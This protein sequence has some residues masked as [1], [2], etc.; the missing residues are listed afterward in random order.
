MVELPISF[1]EKL[2]N[3]LG[4]EELE[5]YLEA[6]NNPRYYGLRVNNKKIST[7][8]FLKISPFDLKPIPWIANGFFY[9]GENI[10]PAKHPYFF[11]GLYYLQ[12]PSAM[13][14]A[15]RLPV[16]AGDRVLD[17][18]AAPGGKSTELAARIGD[19]GLLVS[20]DMSFSR[21]KGLLKNI[22]LFGIGN[23]LVISEDGTKLEKYFP[24]Y[25][26]GILLDAPCSGEGMFRKNSKM[27]TAWESEGPEFF[28][29]IQ[30][31]LIISAAHM[32]KPGGHLLYST[33]TFDLREN[34]EVIQYLL[35]NESDMEIVDMMPY[36]GFYK[37]I[38]LARNKDLEKTV[39]IF[40]QRMEAEGH[41][42]AL[43]HKKKTNKKDK[44]FSSIYT[45]KVSKNVLKSDGYKSLLDFLKDINTDKTSVFGEKN[46]P[47]DTNRIDIKEDKVYYMPEATPYLP[48]LR[49]AR[50]GLLL[51]EIKRDRFE[52]SQ[53]LAC[54]L[55]KESFGKVLNF[56]KD[57]IRVSKYLKGETIDVDDIVSSKEKGY[58]LVCVDGFSLGWGKLSGGTLKNK[59]LVGWRLRS[60][61]QDI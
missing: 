44:G 29:P 19:D 55:N 54:T 17:L 43:L 58:Y 11:A 59:Y 15:N 30:K 57:D 28:S 5:R 50:T 37:G 2:E 39:H 61:F 14:P 21:V 34:E 22:E 12:E 7:E 20:N 42:L 60:E 1:K 4:K 51:G 52:P 18:C 48:K 9:D 6:F 45:G 13:T 56:E 26:D 36:E 24:E 35:D 3:I 47:I 10:S 23:S 31:K 16:K 33:C 25:F 41:Y 32:L 40:P 49:F 27:I 38:A 53:A 8:D 46:K